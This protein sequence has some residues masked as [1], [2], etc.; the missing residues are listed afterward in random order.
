MENDANF[1]AWMIHG[2]RPVADPAEVRDRTHRQAIAAARI[3]APRLIG[4]LAASIAAV[5]PAAKSVEADCCAAG[6][7]A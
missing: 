4:R 7:P 6:S 5:R 2:G 3:R 1:A